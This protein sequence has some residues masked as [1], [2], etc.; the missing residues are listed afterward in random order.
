[1]INKLNV[2]A[3]QKKE[4]TLFNMLPHVAQTEPEIGQAV[5]AA[6]VAAAAAAASLY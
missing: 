4:K 6:A 3:K 1:M 2:K 5:A